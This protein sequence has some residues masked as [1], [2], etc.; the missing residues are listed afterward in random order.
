MLFHPCGRYSYCWS[1]EK[2]SRVCVY[3]GHIWFNTVSAGTQALPGRNTPLHVREIVE[4]VERKG[5][6][7]K[8]NAVSDSEPACLLF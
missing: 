7:V 5:K 3:R 1:W 4:A 8:V 2:L 6:S